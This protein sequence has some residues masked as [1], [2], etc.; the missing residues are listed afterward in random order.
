MGPT[1]HDCPHQPTCTNTL[2][3]ACWH[4]RS[5]NIFILAY[6][7]TTIPMICWT[8]STSCHPHALLCPPKT[9][10]CCSD[11]PA[12]ATHPPC[13]SRNTPPLIL[14]CGESPSWANADSGSRGSVPC[15]ASSGG[16]SRNPTLRPWPR[17]MVPCNAVGDWFPLYDMGRSERLPLAM[18]FGKNN[19][20]VGGEQ[21]RCVR[22]RRRWL[23]GL[24]S[25]KWHLR[26]A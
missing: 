3:R 21:D 1:Q 26:G 11:P 7:L 20:E 5:D 24:D 16:R 9:G 8:Y 2:Q 23:L 6:T 14:G 25:R 15:S 22:G 12:L 17:S 19:R 18:Q 13:L 10:R 4:T